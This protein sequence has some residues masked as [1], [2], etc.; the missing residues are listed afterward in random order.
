MKNLITKYKLSIIGA[1]LGAVGGYFYYIFVGC[2][3][4]S[5]PI[6]SNPYM[7]ILWGAVMGYLIFDLFKNKNQKTQVDENKT[8]DKE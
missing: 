1:V 5:C 3:S 4:G 6:T 8:D 7:S 2:N